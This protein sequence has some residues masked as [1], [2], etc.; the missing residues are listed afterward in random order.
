MAVFLLLLVAFGV[1]TTKSANFQTY[2]IHQYLNSLAKKLKTTISVESV[3]VSFFSGVTLQKLYVEDLH[4]DT[5]AF[6]NHLNVDLS[7]FSFQEKRI[8][9]DE[10]NIDEAYFN[11]KKYKQDST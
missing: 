7:E 5:L 1:A 11:L 10:V 6:I 9:V 8:V 4:Q 3:K 2:L